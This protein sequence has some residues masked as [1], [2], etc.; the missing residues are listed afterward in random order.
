MRNFFAKIKKQKIYFVLFLLIII[1][2]SYLRFSGFEWAVPEKPYYRAGYQDESFVINLILQMDP[3]D[4]NL[5]YFINPSFHYYTLVIAMKMAHL[6]GYVKT[7]AQPVMT[8]LQGQPVEKIIL[9][10]YHKL[11]VIG[12][13]ITMI[14]GILTVLLVYLIGLKLYD[15]KTGLIA[16]FI[17]AILP[18]HVFQSHFFVVDSP[19]VFWS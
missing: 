13:I 19:A 16:S 10:D 2:A 14:E 3:E 9:D 12:R 6:L 1:L 18:T 15:K 4:L 11:Y 5:H 17:F 7:F 8:N